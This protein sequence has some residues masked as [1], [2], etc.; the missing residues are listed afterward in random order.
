MGFLQSHSLGINITP[1][2]PPGTQVGIDISYRALL[3]SWLNIPV[4]VSTA[5]A[6]L[7]RI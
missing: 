6:D 5:S 1:T 3:M 4:A 2:P 7:T